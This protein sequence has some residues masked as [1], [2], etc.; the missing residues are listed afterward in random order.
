MTH[1]ALACSQTKG[2]VVYRISQRH[3]KCGCVK[4]NHPIVCHRH[5]SHDDPRGE[6]GGCGVSVYPGRGGRPLP[7]ASTCHVTSA[8][9]GMG[10]M[11]PAGLSIYP[12]MSHPPSRRGEAFTIGVE[13]VRPIQKADWRYKAKTSDTTRLTAEEKSRLYSLLL[14]TFCS[15][16]LVS[17]LAIFDSFY[18]FFILW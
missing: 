5:R 10:A 15:F 6:G 14:S 3:F 2:M 12:G 8:E 11:W 9:V 4:L 1:F 16:C 18:L 7:G 17:L 13:G